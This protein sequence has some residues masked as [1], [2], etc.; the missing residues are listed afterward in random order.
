MTNP[1]KERVKLTISEVSLEEHFGDSGKKVQFKAKQRD[2]IE[3]LQYVTYRWNLFE[4][5]VKGKEI[6]V[7]LETVT[8]VAGDNTYTDRKVM[9]LYEN[10]QP[11]GQQQKKAWSGGGSRTSDASIEGQVAAKCIT[12]LLAHDKEVPAVAL[13]GFWKWIEQ[14]FSPPVTASVE[15]SK[16]ITDEQKK[17]I[18]QLASEKEY[19]KEHL[20]R[21]VKSFS[22]AEK[23]SDLT[24]LESQTLISMLEG[25]ATVEEADAFE[26]DDIPF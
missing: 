18:A 20:L 17:R 15:P 3:E 13:S 25:G 22:K 14:R 24:E 2:K 21:L 23:S 8:R 4:Y 11:V 9:V 19:T 7:D 6:D 26:V 12:E 1:I 16:S 5:L 10:G